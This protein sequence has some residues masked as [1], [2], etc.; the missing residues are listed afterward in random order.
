MAT[1]F[2]LP[3]HHIGDRF[4]EL[5]MKDTLVKGIV[6]L[7]GFHFLQVRWCKGEWCFAQGFNLSVKQTAL[8]SPQLSRF[9]RL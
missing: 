2:R 5:W 1:F 3:G 6:E 4:E 7:E 9:T 8:S